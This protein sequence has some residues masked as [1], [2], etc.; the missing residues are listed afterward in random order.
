MN[1]DNFE[2]MLNESMSARS[3]VAIGEK[4]NAKIVSIGK[5]YVFLDLG[6]RSEGLLLRAEVETDGVLRVAEGDHMQV[7]PMSMRDGVF[8]CATRIGQR[9]LER[10]DDKSD[11]YAQIRSAAE[12]G[13]TVEGTVKAVN[14]GGLEVDIYG[15]RAFCPVSQIENGFCADASVH[16]NHTYGFRISRFEEGS[17]NVVV[18]RRALLEDEAKERATAAW[19]T[20]S[21]GDT[22][23]GV[24]S[25]LQPYGAFIRFDDV[26]GLL[27]VS[28]ISHKRIGHPDEVLSPGQAVT[29]QIKAM[30]P[31]TRKISLS[32]KSLSADP[33]DE[34]TDRIQAGSVVNGQ[35]TRITTF[36][37]FV[38]L[39]DGVEG[40]VH[41]SRLK[42]GQHVANPR[43]VVSV[44]AQVRVR[45]VEIDGE[46]RR[47]SLSLVD[48][49]AEEEQAITAQF[50][51]AS[52]ALPRSMG[53]LGDLLSGS[54]SK[55]TPR[56]T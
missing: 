9:A 7:V 30:D 25:S 33:W 46:S 28:E 34:L 45:V 18:S 51:D 12:A 4:V 40:L 22:R 21:V 43:E 14:K 19:Q 17:R 24:V 37:A 20:L 54:L 35:V 31:A 16:L 38:S 52:A 49:A 56:G 15:V 2:E 41:I 47:I 23:T 39:A 8:M 11:L 50:R 42:P 10:S 48:E 6:T 53:T 27:H 26:E 5:E 32:L 13:L 44:G 55:K 1:T 36:G 3:G 29:V